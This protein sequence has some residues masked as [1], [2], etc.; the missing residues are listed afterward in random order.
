MTHCDPLST[1]NFTYLI[2]CCTDTYLSDY[3]AFFT[4][5]SDVQSKRAD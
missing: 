1:Y 4:Q 5:L 3:D 2:E